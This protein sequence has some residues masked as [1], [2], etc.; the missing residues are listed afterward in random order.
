MNL[1]LING[2]DQDHFNAFMEKFHDE[3]HEEF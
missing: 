3:K 1:E 2:K